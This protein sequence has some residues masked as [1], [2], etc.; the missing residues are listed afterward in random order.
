MVVMNLE[1]QMKELDEQ[2]EEQKIRINFN[3]W[4]KQFPSQLNT[5]QPN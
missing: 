5:D 2:E 1:D 4:D 3:L